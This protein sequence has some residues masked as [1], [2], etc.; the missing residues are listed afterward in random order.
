MRAR[1]PDPANAER[2]TLAHWLQSAGQRGMSA[3][4]LDERVER[5]AHL[6]VTPWRT[7]LRGMVQ[8]RWC[9]NRAKWFWGQVPEQSSTQI[10][11]G[12]VQSE[13]ITGRHAK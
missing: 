9:P 6:F 13:E 10:Q 3:A 12:S 2:K 1:T 4:E 7:H 11:D 5:C 8:A